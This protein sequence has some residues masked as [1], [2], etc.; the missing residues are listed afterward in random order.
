MAGGG[1]LLDRLDVLLTLDGSEPTSASEA[2]RRQLVRS[3]RLYQAPLRV[4][5]LQLR[6]CPE[7]K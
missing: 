6:L 3:D 1:E 5:T 7:W 4:E 2:P